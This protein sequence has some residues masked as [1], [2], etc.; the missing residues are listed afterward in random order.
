MADL[1]FMLNDDNNPNI[2][3]VTSILGQLGI[4]PQTGKYNVDKLLEIAASRRIITKSLL[5]KARVGD[6]EDLLANHLI[7][8][9]GLREAWSQ[10][11]PGYESFLFSATD[12]SAI[13]PMEEF[14]LK[15]LYQR[16]AGTKNDRS[17]GLLTSDYGNTHYI[18]SLTVTTPSD[19]LSIALVKSIYK[20]VSDFYVEKSIES[21]QRVY[22]L[23]LAE[24]DSIDQRISDIAYDVAL[25]GDK[26]SGAFRYQNNVKSALLEKELAGLEVVSEEII[27]NVSRA[28]YALKT[29]TPLIQVLDVPSYPLSPQK[30]SLY[31]LLLIGLLGGFLLFGLVQYLRL[32]FRYI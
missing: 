29:S 4:A 19:S 27:K 2:S 16:V 10:R 1:S 30:G 8:K 12:S 18:M 6:Q 3:G 21:S 17:K 5:T 32:I 20:E 11:D 15:D 22:N 7:E 26:N 9:L 23:L 24:K 31:K 14:A 25:I 13:N 28:E